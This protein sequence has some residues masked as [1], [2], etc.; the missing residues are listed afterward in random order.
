MYTPEVVVVFCLFPILARNRTTLA[1]I[2]Y[3][4][5]LVVSSPAG[6]PSCHRLLFFLF[7][8]FWVDH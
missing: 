1:S 2:E 5:L 3:V 4:N 6:N 8:A 7:P